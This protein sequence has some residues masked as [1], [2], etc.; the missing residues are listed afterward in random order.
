MRR[1]Y[2]LEDGIDGKKVGKI[3]IGED[4]RRYIWEKIGG[5]YAYMGEGRGRFIHNTIFLLKLLQPRIIFF[6][7]INYLNVLYDFQI[8]FPWPL[9][10]MFFLRNPAQHVYKT[11]VPSLT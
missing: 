9:N 3:Y 6:D 8:F 4:R 10:K 1:R 7:N 5:R 11:T 2:L